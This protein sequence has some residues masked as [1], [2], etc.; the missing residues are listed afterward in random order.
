MSAHRSDDQPVRVSGWIWATLA[1]LGA[2]IGLVF[3]VL[4]DPPF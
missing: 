1:V 3:L 4:A 2:M